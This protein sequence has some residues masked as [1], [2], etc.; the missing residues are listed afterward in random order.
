MR[1]RVAALEEAI[2]RMAIRKK[3]EI[4]ACSVS[5]EPSVPDEGTHSFLYNPKFF[6]AA[7]LVALVAIVFYFRQSAK[8]T[9][10]GDEHPVANTEKTPIPRYTRMLTDSSRRH[11]LAEEARRRNHR[12]RTGVRAVQ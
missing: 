5:S 6:F 1:E 7:G 3:Q 9:R 10:F 12:F 2:R 8:V 11:A 4:A